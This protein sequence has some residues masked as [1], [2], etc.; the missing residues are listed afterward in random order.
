M[1]DFIVRKEVKLAADLNGESSLPALENI[2][3]KQKKY[4]ATYDDCRGL[5]LGHGFVDTSFP[6]RI[7]NRY[8]RELKKR[9]FDVVI[10][11]NEYLRAEFIPSLGGKL[12][13]L[14]DKMEQR[15]LLFNNP[16][17][18][19]CNLATRNAWTSGGVEFNIGEFGHHAYTCDPLFAARTQLD[20]G[21]PVLRMYE[22]SRIRSVVYQMDFWLPDE[23][24]VLFARMRIMN[25]NSKV[26]PMYWWSNAAVPDWEK[27]RVLVPAGE[28]FMQNKALGTHVV[29][30]PYHHDLDM[31]YNRNN[32]CSDTFYIIPENRRRFICYTDKDGYTYAHTSTNRLKSRKLFVWGNGEGGKRWQEFLSGE[33][34]P[35]SYIELQAGL[36]NTQS[37]HIPMPPLT[38]WEWVE[39]YGA[40]QLDP[41][42]AHGEFQT[43]CA[44]VETHLDHVITAQSLE[45]ILADTRK[46]AV[47]PAKELLFAGSGWGALENQRRTLCGEPLLP[48]HLDFLGVGPAQEQW[49][50]LLESGSMSEHESKEVPPSWMRQEEWVEMLEQAVE[51]TDKANWYTWMQLGC[52]YM[53]DRKFRLAKEALEKSMVL[54]ENCWALYA[55]ACLEKTNDDP[56]KAGQMILKAA[57]INPSDSSLAVMTTRFLHEAGLYQENIAF[58]ET[59]EK[60]IATNSRIQLYYAY[61]LLHMGEVYRADAVLHADGGIDMAD[62][63]EAETIIT[64]LW[65]DIEEAKAAL[66]GREFDRT[67]AAPPEKF[68]FR[69]HA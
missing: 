22:F 20:D 18:R 58:I 62:I 50:V 45:A 68:D 1:T 54:K 35:G 43:A 8:T 16:V 42:V 61:A 67:T 23:S 27:G 49:M 51:G 3:L 4:V 38:A 66:E 53:A 6:H 41:E 55:L 56:V 19:Y 24:K 47:S 65:F 63:R 7:H 15:D 2:P 57:Q 44:A 25:P 5:F 31:S 69:M 64:Q 12:W 36:A 48:E 34:N 59:L 21:T 37:E 30:I 11:E 29:S 32:F 33:G 13:S 28:A 14:Y 46:M 60:D 39:T 17:V 26:S 52:A 40:V 10:L 9:E